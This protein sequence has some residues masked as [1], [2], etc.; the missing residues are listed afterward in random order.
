V[1]AKIHGLDLFPKKAKLLGEKIQGVPKKPLSGNFLAKIFQK[2][3][4]KMI[5]RGIF[6]REIDCTHRKRLPGHEIYDFRFFQLFS[7]GIP[8]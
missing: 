8:T 2:I 5:I 6:M 3:L 1:V 4:F 7:V